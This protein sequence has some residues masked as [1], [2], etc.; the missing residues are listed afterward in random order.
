[1]RKIYFLLLLLILFLLPIIAQAHPGRTNI[2]GCH[3]CRTNCKE[4]GFKEGAYHCHT[5]K[6]KIAKTEVR[7]EAKD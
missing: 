6:I 5:E 1:M 2:V 4:W 7:T 3:V